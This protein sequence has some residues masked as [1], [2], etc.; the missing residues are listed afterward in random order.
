MGVAAVG[1]SKAAHWGL[2]QFFQCT[3]VFQNL[4]CHLIQRRTCN[5]GVQYGVASHLMPTIQLFILADRDALCIVQAGIEVESSLH[6]I[7]V[8]QF[9]KTAVFFAAIVKTEGQSLVLA[10]GET[11]I[12]IFQAHTETSCK[13]YGTA[14]LP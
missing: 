6:A 14:R 7:L 11:G 12:N 10:A 1:V 13:P 5:G 9:H 8:E 4:L 3:A 2:D